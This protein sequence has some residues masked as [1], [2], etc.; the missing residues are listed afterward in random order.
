MSDA[1]WVLKS[2]EDLTSSEWEALCDGCG[3]CCL[4]K[5]EDEDTGEVFY[6]RVACRQLDLGTCRCKSYA[7]RTAKVP[8]CIDL[9]ATPDAMAWLPSTC[10]YRLR[11]QG[12]SLPIWHPLVSGD[13][14]S[15]HMA[16]ISIR[17]LAV[18]ESGN[19]DLE[20][21]IIEDLI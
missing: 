15:V 17:H 8:G 6:T 5:L 13:L 7:D 3:R 9:K 20:D 19:E 10:A 21:F 16:G 12:E 2:L 18:P 11:Q 4:H 1:F 14:D